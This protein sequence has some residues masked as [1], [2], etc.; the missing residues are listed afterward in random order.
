MG[1]PITGPTVEYAGAAP[2]GDV[3][4]SNVFR[5]RYRQTKPYDRPLPYKS[6][7]STT[8]SGGGKEY[9]SIGQPFQ[10]WW[11]NLTALDTVSSGAY[12]VP[13]PGRTDWSELD[14]RLSLVLNKAREKFFAKA[15]SR[16][17]LSVDILQRKQALQMLT[18]RVTQVA[19]TLLAIKKG[20]FREALSELGIKKPA[21]WRPAVRNAGGLWLEYSYGWKP[22]VQDIFDAAKVLSAPVDDLWIHESSSNQF[23]TELIQSNVGTP[24]DHNVYDTNYVVLKVY[25]RVGAVVSCDNPNLQALKNA[26]LTNPLSWAWELIPFSF[27]VDWLVDV[28]GFIESLDDGVGLTITNGFYTTGWK[29]TSKV[30]RNVVKMWPTGSPNPYDGTSMVKLRS[31]AGMDRSLG[32]PTVK[33]ARKLKVLTNLNRGLNA[34]SLLAQALK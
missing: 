34:A 9:V 20:K 6:R 3:G 19:R 31:V 12:E 18:G 7:L 13:D 5:Q 33:L 14:R 16:V 30:Q 24:W 8:T 21:G 2:Q 29:G 23:I 32:L 28:G 10:S 22:L 25:A 27:V 1:L 11:E 17:G 4:A 15:N 26:G